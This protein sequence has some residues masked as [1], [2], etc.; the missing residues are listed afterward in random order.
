MFWRQS[1]LTETGGRWLIGAKDR[2]L[3]ANLLPRGVHFPMVF[4]YIDCPLSVSA[5]VINFA[6]KLAGAFLIFVRAM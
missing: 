3:A 1:K 5:A 2:S 6:S 4:G